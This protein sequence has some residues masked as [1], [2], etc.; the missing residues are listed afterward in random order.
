MKAVKSFDFIDGMALFVGGKMEMKSSLIEWMTRRTDCANFSILSTAVLVARRRWIGTRGNRFGIWH[1]WR[2]IA[3]SVQGLMVR[4]GDPV[5]VLEPGP[6]FWSMIEIDMGWYADSRFCLSWGGMRENWWRLDD[7]SFDECAEFALAWR[8]VWN[9]WT[10]LNVQNPF[11]RTKP[12]FE[13]RTQAR[14]YLS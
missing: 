8:R 5:V 6:F 2:Y 14:N 10:F 9:T 1:W 3:V 11:A 12:Y 7:E 13:P 4:S